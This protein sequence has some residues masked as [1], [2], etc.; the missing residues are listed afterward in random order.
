MFKNARG[1]KT[2]RVAFTEW[3]A[4]ATQNWMWGTMSGGTFYKPASLQEKIGYDYIRSDW[5]V[6][7]ID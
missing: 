1:L 4:T 6:V 7:N 2:V 3:P 5:T